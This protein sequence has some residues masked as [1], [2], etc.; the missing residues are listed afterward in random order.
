HITDAGLTWEDG[1]VEGPPE[2]L[3]ATDDVG[4]RSERRERDEAATFL[5]DILR[6]GPVASKQIAADA[7]ANGIA[8]STLWRAKSDLGTTAE[9]ARKVEGN[10]GP[11]YWALP[12]KP[13]Q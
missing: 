5:R 12:T 2:Q 11:W 13:L 9:R 10:T 6:D 8:R 1:T 3:L 4:T 7:T